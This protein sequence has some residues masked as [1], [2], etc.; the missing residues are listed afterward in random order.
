M[1]VL[2]LRGCD[3]NNMY[4]WYTNEIYSVIKVFI[5]TI[6]IV[7]GNFLKFC[8][9]EY[10]II[11]IILPSIILF[12][13]FDGPIIIIINSTRAFPPSLTNH[14]RVKVLYFTIN[15][16]S[17]FHYRLTTS[18]RSRPY[19]EEVTLTPKAHNRGLTWLKDT[20]RLNN[21]LLYRFQ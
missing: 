10:I 16:P 2:T 1:Y 13:C 6:N 11:I 9:Y 12:F 7:E 20:S 18:K 4:T 19:V 15:H 21:I 5:D 17:L 8:K 14:P 3:E